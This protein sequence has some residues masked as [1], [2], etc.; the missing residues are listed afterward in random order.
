M[1]NSKRKKNQ[2]E[3]E[4]SNVDVLFKLE[5]LEAKLEKINNLNTQKVIE[6]IEHLRGSIHD[7]QANQEQMQKEITGLKQ[8]RSILVDQ[9]EELRSTVNQVRIKQ[10]ENEQYMRRHNL[11]FFNIKDKEN[12]KEEESL[13]LVCGVIKD[14]LQLR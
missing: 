10:N 6:E 5:I 7:L 11:R 3:E 4:H 8:E 9:L 12:E 1:P 2:S 13:E 14:K